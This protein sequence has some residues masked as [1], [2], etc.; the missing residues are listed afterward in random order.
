MTLCQQKLT[1]VTRPSSWRPKWPFK[2]RHLVDGSKA[3]IMAPQHVV[4]SVT[5]SRAS[6]VT[7]G[8]DLFL[9]HCFL[10]YYEVV[11]SVMVIFLCLFYICTFFIYNKISSYTTYYI[12]YVFPKKLFLEKIMQFLDQFVCRNLKITKGTSKGTVSLF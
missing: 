6:H 10:L 1:R 3:I 11:Y 12:D 9:L 7:K 5:T 8:I 2:R 4:V